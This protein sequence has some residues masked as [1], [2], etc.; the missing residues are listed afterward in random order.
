MIK[1]IQNQDIQENL[2][3]KYIKHRKLISRIILPITRYLRARN[4]EK[5]LSKKKW[6]SILDVGCGDGYFLRR[7]E[8]KFK[9]RYGLDLMLGDKIE[10]K[11]DFPDN[12]F[13]TVTMLAVIEHLDYP[14]D[15][16][17]EISR[18]LKQ[19]GSF[20]FTTPSYKAEKFINLYA[21]DIKEEHKQYFTKENISIILSS[22]LKLVNYN[23]FEFG[24]NQCFHFKKI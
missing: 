23:T 9:E 16:I 11:L 15:I 10:K 21:K 6:G 24:L 20:I 8:G 13:D 5:Y 18:I 17:A 19:N 1:L 2:D 3:F 22:S 4:T 12:S 7:C 14:K